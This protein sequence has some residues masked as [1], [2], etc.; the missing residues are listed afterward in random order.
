MIEPPWLD[1]KPY[2]IQKKGIVNDPT[3]LDFLTVFNIISLKE[4]R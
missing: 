1:A 4:A 3:A 2:Y